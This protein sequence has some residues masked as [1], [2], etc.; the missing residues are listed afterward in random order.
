M[1]TTIVNATEYRD[2]PLAMLIES[3]TNP[4][5]IF[6]ENALKEMAETVRTATRRRDKLRIAFIERRILEDEKDVGINP[7]L[8]VADGQQNTRRLVSVGVHLFEASLERCFLLVGRQ[9]CQQQR[10]AY[11][12]FVGIERIHRSGYKVGQFQT[13]RLCCQFAYVRIGVDPQTPFIVSHCRAFGQVA[14]IM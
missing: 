8:Q 13:L 7:E 10:M 1:N 14:S 2:L 3:P 9:L 6:E 5:R 11:A 4:R 12:D